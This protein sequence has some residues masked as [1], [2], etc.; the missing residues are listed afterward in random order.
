MRLINLKHCRSSG[1]FECIV[2][3][4]I[5]P[6]TI[7]DL[8]NRGQCQ[9]FHQIVQVYQWDHVDFQ[10]FSN[11]R[12][13]LPSV[14]YNNT[15]GTAQSSRKFRTRILQHL[16]FIIESRQYVLTVLDKF[17]LRNAARISSLKTF[18]NCIQRC[19]CIFSEFQSYSAISW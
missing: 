4:C 3:C 6:L 19:F 17:R 15:C 13:S 2:K 7:I 16:L 10:R 8:S 11:Y 18:S 14:Y 12:G 9:C 5:A 1:R